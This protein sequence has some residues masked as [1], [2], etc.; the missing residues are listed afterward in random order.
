MLNTMFYVGIGYVLGGLITYCLIQIHMRRTVAAYHK[1]QHK[2]THSN[3]EECQKLINIGFYA[4]TQ[5][6][7]DMCQEMQASQCNIKLA[8]DD[9]QGEE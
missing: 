6:M 3:T 4:A 1:W 9:E 2:Q 5:L 7:M 8:T